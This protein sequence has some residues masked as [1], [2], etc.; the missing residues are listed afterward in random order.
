MT[1]RRYTGEAVAD[2]EKDEG[3]VDRE[4][5]IDA[6]TAGGADQERETGQGR[7]AAETIEMIDEGIIFPWSNLFNS[8]LAFLYR[9]RDRHRRRSRSRSR[10]RRRSRS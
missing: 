6:E 2:Q 5:E 7:E 1:Q 3:V 9:D 4:T 8:H 10:E